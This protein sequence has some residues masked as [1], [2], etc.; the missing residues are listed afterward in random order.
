[1]QVLL[2]A[3]MSPAGC[4]TD[5]HVD[6]GGSAVWY[7]VVS[8]SKV[9]IMYP[10]TDA[11]LAAFEEWSST[12]HQVQTFAMTRHLGSTGIFRQSAP[13]QQLS[14][15]GRCR[16]ALARDQQPLRNNWICDCCICKYLHIIRLIRAPPARPPGLT[17]SLPSRMHRLQMPLL[18]NDARHHTRTLELPS[19]KQHCS[20]LPKSVAGT[21]LQVLRAID[22]HCRQQASMGTWQQRAW[23]VH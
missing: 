23:S 1:M 14:L 22:L 17:L 4:F 2:Y 9:F 7:H 18:L 10:P 5:F 3:L 13:K 20:W 19:K 12:E 6:F 21:A 15:F 8:G 11:N 16:H